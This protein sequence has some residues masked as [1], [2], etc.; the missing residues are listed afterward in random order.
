MKRYLDWTGS[1]NPTDS[2]N[3]G[4]S[5]TYDKANRD[6]QTNWEDREWTRRRN[7]ADKKTWELFRTLAIVII[8][9]VVI[10]F[11]IVALQE[12]YYSK[13]AEIAWAR[14][15]NTSDIIKIEAIK[16]YG[17]EYIGYKNYHEQTFSHVI[18]IVRDAK[19]TKIDVPNESITERN[20]ALT[21][22]ITTQDGVRHTFS[23]LTRG[24]LVIDGVYYENTYYKRVQQ[25]RDWVQGEKIMGDVP[26]DFEY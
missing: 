18:E 11:P 16:G 13:D 19:G 6:E 23:L 2:V 14:N 24:Y 26:E 7:D 8:G 5:T 1:G 12:L 20:P 15:L 3:I 21:F 10:A 9:V 17:T 4:I 22:Y 25:I